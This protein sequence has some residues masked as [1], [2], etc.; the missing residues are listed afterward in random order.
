VRIFFLL[1][2]LT[3][4]VSRMLPTPAH[5]GVRLML[6]TFFF[7]AGFV[8]WAFELIE[9]LAERFR[10]EEY[11]TT[12]VLGVAAA[13]LLLP[14]AYRLARVHPFELSYYN[15]V[16]GGLAGAQR[17]GFEPTYWYDAVIPQVLRQM[18]DEHAGLPRGAT[19]SLPEPRSIVEATTLPGLE[20]ARFL[21]ELPEKRINPEVFVEL[22]AMQR[23]RRDIRIPDIR[24]VPPATSDFPHAAL[25]THSSKASPFTRLL[26]ALKPQA[27]WGHDG[28]R[29]F[30]LYDPRGVARAWGL[31]ILLDATDYSQPIVKPRVDYDL[32]E[33]AK[34]NYRA[35]YAAALR[36]TS[37]GL[38]QALESQED[39]ETKAV[40][41]RLAAHRD[42]LEVLLTR[43]KE[44]LVEAVEIVNRA[45]QKR[46]RVLELLVEGYDGYL[47]ADILGDY[48]DE[49][50]TPLAP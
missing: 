33:L 10:S 2:M 45:A 39:P 29:L 36:V 19:L 41:R 6:P 15:G 4:P 43:R 50:L 5:D 16:V 13:F 18:N 32:I 3:L 26:Y 20:S 37:D 42:T 21:R 14:P 31:W 1:N 49:G 44:A 38:D 34:G 47:P 27:A 7:L 24:G 48:L 12:P 23:L 25:L 17:L 22:W 35:L 11:S 9:R 8:G 40:I 46:P 28:V 30:S